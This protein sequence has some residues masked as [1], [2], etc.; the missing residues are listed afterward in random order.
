MK[1]AD[2][3]NTLSTGERMLHQERPWGE[4]LVASIT[5]LS[6]AESLSY[7]LSFLLPVWK[8]GMMTL[9]GSSRG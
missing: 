6:Y 7:F 2:R 4:A 3:A 1:G 8:M 9:M 5:L